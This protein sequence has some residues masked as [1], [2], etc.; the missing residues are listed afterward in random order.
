MQ[1]MRKLA[2]TLWIYI[3]AVVVVLV[4]RDDD[5]VW[6]TVQYD[7][8]CMNLSKQWTTANLGEVL[9]TRENGKLGSWAS[10]VRS[11]AVPAFG[12]LEHVFLNEDPNMQRLPKLQ[13]A[14]YA[15]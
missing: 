12:L 8:T 6:L 14:E 4:R 7:R 15:K 9:G 3:F 11:R 5:H 10:Q 2:E 1:W 13:I